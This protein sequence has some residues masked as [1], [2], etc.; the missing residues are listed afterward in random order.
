MLPD[1]LRRRSLKLALE[2]LLFLVVFLLLKAYLQRDLVTGEAPPLEGELLNGQTVSLQ[3]YRGKPLLLHFWAS[4]CSV[5]KLEQGSINAVSADHP[6]LTIAMQSGTAEEVS[7]YLA[8]QGLDFPVLVDE[9]GDLARRFGV[10]GVPTSFILDP[11]GRIAFAEVGYT[12]G[13]G[14]RARLWWA[15]L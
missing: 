7:D 1:T 3:D 9:Q 8:Q 10:R 14:L 15:G 6:V 2:I 5:C 4:W 13:W 11:S 12:T